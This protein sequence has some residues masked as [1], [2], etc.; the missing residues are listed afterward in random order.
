MWLQTTRM[1]RF[2][3]EAIGMTKED[4]YQVRVS[5]I[6]LAAVSQAQTR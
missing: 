2:M 3:E 4:V 1:V 6:L 5:A